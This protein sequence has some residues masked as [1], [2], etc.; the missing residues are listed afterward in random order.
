MLLFVF[1]SHSRSC[2]SLLIGIIHIVSVSQWVT[3]RLSTSGSCSLLGHNDSMVGTFQMVYFTRPVVAYVFSSPCC[4][5]SLLSLILSQILALFLKKKIS[6]L[7]LSP[8]LWSFP[9]Y[10]RPVQQKP[11][12][13]GALLE[14]EGLPGAPA[15]SSSTWINISLRWFV[16]GWD[17]CL[18]NKQ[19]W[20]QTD[21]PPKLRAKIY[22]YAIVLEIKFSEYTVTQSFGALFTP[23]N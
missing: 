17:V 4:Y 12:K 21:L 3:H 8:I 15:F 22:F 1:P 18:G 9:S 7:F 16:S 14:P 23:I 19:E 20:K 10:P 2:S 11:L 6:F 13:E 5:S